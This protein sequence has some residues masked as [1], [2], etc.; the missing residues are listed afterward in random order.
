MEVSEQAL[1]DVK[2][3]VHQCVPTNADL[4]P[5]GGHSRGIPLD[6]DGCAA[7]KKS[8]LSILDSHKKA[9]SHA[10]HQDN[11]LPYASAAQQYYKKLQW[12]ILCDEDSPPDYDPSDLKEPTILDSPVVATD[13]EAMPVEVVADKSDSIFLA[14]GSLRRR[15][16]DY[17]L[18]T[19]RILARGGF[20]V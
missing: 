11:P 8:R 10:Q 7:L 3:W 18:W 14:D 15:P 17:R 4:A 13:Y 19:E 9:Q 5:Q 6:D 12:S 1:A 16:E 2:G 20:M